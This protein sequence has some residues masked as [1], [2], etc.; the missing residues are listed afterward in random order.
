[1]ISSSLE[2]SKH[3]GLSWEKHYVMSIDHIFTLLLCD[4]EQ[5]SMYKLQGFFF[6]KPD[7]IWSEVLHKIIK[8]F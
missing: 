6:P 7:W 5:L 2:S 4:F 8:I 3:C 1:M